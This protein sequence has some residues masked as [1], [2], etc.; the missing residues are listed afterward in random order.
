[1]DEKSQSVPWCSNSFQLLGFS[2]TVEDNTLSLR[3]PFAIIEPWVW[4]RLGLFPAC[5]NMSSLFKS[6]E[7]AKICQRLKFLARIV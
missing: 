2:G 1:M 6:V 7:N 3:N 5:F 4:R